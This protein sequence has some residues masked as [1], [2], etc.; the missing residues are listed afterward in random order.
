M[1]SPPEQMR[2]GLDEKLA[3]ALETTRSMLFTG[4]KDTRPDSAER[5][6]FH[7]DQTSLPDEPSLSPEI[8]TLV[9]KVAAIMPPTVLERYFQIGIVMATGHKTGHDAEL[10]RYAER[11]A[12]LHRFSK[13]GEQTPANLRHRKST[14]TQPVDVARS[15]DA[16]QQNASKARHLPHPKN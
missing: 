15:S 5:I 4:W 14:H 3:Y 16:P 7:P 13:T 1:A 10:A 9:A 6:L 12:Q 8:H 11:F 2:R